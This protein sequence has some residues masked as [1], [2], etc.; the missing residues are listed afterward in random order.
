MC[1]HSTH[2]VDSI[3]F[4]F[5]HSYLVDFISLQPCA[6]CERRRGIDSAVTFLSL[7]WILLS[8]SLHSSFFFFNFGRFHFPF[9]RVCVHVFYVI[10]S[11]CFMVCRYICC[12]F[13]HKLIRCHKLFCSTWISSISFIF[14]REEKRKATKNLDVISALCMHSTERFFSPCTFAHSFDCWQQQ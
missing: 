14:S 6:R 7:Y 2:A 3:R 8:V 11:A 12:D 13:Y 5:N 4:V 9:T 1:W 10:L